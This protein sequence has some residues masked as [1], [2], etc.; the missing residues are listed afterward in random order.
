M[1]GFCMK[2]VLSD[3]HILEI[4]EVYKNSTGSYDT[5]AR[6]F[7]V[8]NA[9]IWRAMNK[10]A[11]TPGLRKAVAKGLGRWKKRHRRAAEFTEDRAALYDAMLVSFDMTTTEVLN[12]ILD[13]WI[14]V[15]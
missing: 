10:G 8:N 4:L 15:N 11:V 1:G 7:E 12:S 13:A 3:E 2:K 5:V 6:L 14:L 9:T